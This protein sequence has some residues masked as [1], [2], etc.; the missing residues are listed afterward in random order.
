[1][2]VDTP[3]YDRGGMTLQALAVKVGDGTVLP[4][5]V[6]AGTRRTAT[7]SIDRGQINHVRRGRRADLNLDAFFN[8]WLYTPEGPVE[9]VVSPAARKGPVGPWAPRIRSDSS[10]LWDRQAGD[11]A[12]PVPMTARPGGRRRAGTVSPSAAC[13]DRRS[14]MFA[15]VSAMSSHQRAAG[16]GTA[17]TRPGA[18]GTP[19]PRGPG[20]PWSGVVALGQPERVH[21]PEAVPGAVAPPRAPARV[22]PRPAGVRRERV[23]RPGSARPR[24][25]RPH[26]GRPARAGRASR[27][28]RAARPSRR[29]SGGSP[30]SARAAPRSRGRPPSS[31]RTVAMAGR[32]IVNLQDVEDAAAKFGIR[33]AWRRGSPAPRS[34]SRSRGSRCSRWPRAS[35]SP[36]ATAIA[37]RRRSTWCS[38]AARR[39]SSR[40]SGELGEWDAV[41]IPAE[42]RALFEAAP[43]GAEVLAD[44]AGEQGDAEMIKDF[45]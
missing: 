41:R 14:R 4:D 13:A 11:E 16:L 44:G 23:R 6:A 18:S 21:D 9:L 12:V 26:G 35:R 45:W 42:W 1:M 2:F 33:R 22:D 8:P 39:W 32:T 3:V 24:R 25:A 28:A 10:A 31:P 29:R 19:S 30:L 17:N 20:M 27:A 7:R 37:T 38:A 34:G 15:Q 43:D 36:G 5:P 40:T